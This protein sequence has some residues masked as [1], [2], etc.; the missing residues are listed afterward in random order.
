V[1]PHPATDGTTARTAFGI[2][3]GVS[4]TVDAALPLQRGGDTERR[5]F[6]RKKA[7]LVEFSGKARYL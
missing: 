1:P 5:I 4:T 3:Q 7:L 2:M 6:G